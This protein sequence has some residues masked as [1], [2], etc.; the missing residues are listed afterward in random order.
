VRQQI[1]ALATRLRQQAVT[2]AA[3][4]GGGTFVNSYVQNNELVVVVV[5]VNS[6]GGVTDFSYYNAA[7]GQPSANNIGASMNP[8]MGANQ[9]LGS[10]LAANPTIAGT[11]WVNPYTPPP[12][13]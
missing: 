8:N 9:N 12:S 10:F 4:N 11:T 3:A 6:G 5:T 13:N 1:K 7:T 2:N